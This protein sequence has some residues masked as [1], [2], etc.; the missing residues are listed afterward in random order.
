MYVHISEDTAVEVIERLEE[1]VAVRDQA[2]D[3]RW[4]K[5]HEQGA[6]IDQLEREVQALRADNIRLDNQTITIQP[7]GECTKQH[8]PPMNVILAVRIIRAA[9]RELDE[10]DL[11]TL[12]ELVAGQRDQGW[13]KAA[14][15][16][17]DRAKAR[18]ENRFDW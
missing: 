11:E 8:H 17:Y 3:A 15:I 1:K 2:I 13:L 16:L 6:T 9:L 18:P 10:H 7:F 5:I 14:K 12:K 4:E